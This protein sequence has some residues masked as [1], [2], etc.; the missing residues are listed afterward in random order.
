MIIFQDDPLDT[1]LSLKNK[2][3]FFRTLSNDDIKNLIDEIKILSYNQNQVLFNEGSTKS[4]YVLYLLQGK[5]DIY[6]HVNSID[7]DILINSIDNPMILGEWHFLTGR[8]R[9]ATVKAAKD[10]TLVLAFKI[11]IINHKTFE[12]VFYRSAI[13]ELS[14]KL[15]NMN[16]KYELDLVP[17]K[18]I[19]LTINNTDDIFESFLEMK[20]ELDFF[21][22]FSDTYLR[23][24]VRDIELYEV[25]SDYIIFKQGENNSRYM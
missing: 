11:K 19:D 20:P 21:Q 5:V 2:I 3:E 10:K 1:L 16:N 24:L 23:K 14:T 8:P 18:D 9:N 6:K 17:H 22:Q 12:S 25:E 7:S 15:D 4:K 13:M